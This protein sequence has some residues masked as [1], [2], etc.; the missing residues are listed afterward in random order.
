MNPRPTAPRRQSSKLSV[1]GSPDAESLGSRARASSAVSGHSTA[2]WWS[3]A[4]SLAD[5]MDREEL[6]KPW[7][8][9]KVDS[10]VAMEGVTE[11][12]ESTSSGYSS[13]ASMT[14][15]D[16]KMRRPTS[17]ETVVPR[18][19]TSGRSSMRTIS[20]GTTRSRPST[21]HVTRSSTTDSGLTAATSTA[22]LR[23]A[24]EGSPR[25]RRSPP[26]SPIN[27]QGYWETPETLR[28]RQR[29][30]EIGASLC[31]KY[32]NDRV[33]GEFLPFRSEFSH[34]ADSLSPVQFLRS[35]ENVSKTASMPASMQR[36]NT[37][38]GP[39]MDNSTPRLD[40]ERR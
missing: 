8:I 15:H 13:N 25:S 31:Q 1:P 26:I 17:S 28:R 20:S 4:A 27:T 16:T 40:A 21:S 11:R 12:R 10:G 19:R 3:A 35:K 18:A 29:R 6:E 22:S 2:T 23:P 14:S 9:R 34:S 30:A 39:D 36:R 37:C 7:T 5:S 38:P 24:K 33:H 32:P